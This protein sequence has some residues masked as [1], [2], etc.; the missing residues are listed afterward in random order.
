[1]KVPLA[2]FQA[3]ADG[4][5]DSLDCLGVRLQASPM[6]DAGQRTGGAIGHI[7][8]IRLTDRDRIGRDLHHQRVG[9]LSR[10]GVP[11]DVRVQLFDQSGDDRVAGML[12]QGAV[13]A[14]DERNAVVSERRRGAVFG[15]DDVL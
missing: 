8:A 12:A 3:A 1:M 9:V 15:M 13:I 10:L 4:S 6:A 11:D 2:V 14:A 7:R 5:A